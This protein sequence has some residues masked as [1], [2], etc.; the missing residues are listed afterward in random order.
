MHE[1]SLDQEFFAH[2]L[3]TGQ[4]LAVYLRLKSCF[5]GKD[6]IWSLGCRYTGAE[7]L[8]SAISTAPYAPAAHTDLAE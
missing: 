7:M 4:V 5:M 2:A 3:R 6:Q 1:Q 8:G